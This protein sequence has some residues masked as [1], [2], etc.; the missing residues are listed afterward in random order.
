[1]F[2]KRVKQLHNRFK[3]PTYHVEYIIYLVKY[4][5][6]EPHFYQY[7][8]SVKTFF[9]IMLLRLYW[10]LHYQF[11]IVY[12]YLPPYLPMLNKIILVLIRKFIRIKIDKNPY[13]KQEH[14]DTNILGV[15]F[16]ILGSIWKLILGNLF[17]RV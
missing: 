9:A 5:W 4:N 14:K 12:N 15:V 8:F 3:N 10:V 2:L 7:S 11:S 6:S 17:R 1:M 13:V 16:N